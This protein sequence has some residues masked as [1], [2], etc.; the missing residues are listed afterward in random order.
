MLA[1][2]LNLYR[3]AAVSIQAIEGATSRGSEMRQENI[4]ESNLASQFCGLQLTIQLGSFG[5]SLSIVTCFAD[6]LG[7]LS[8]FCGI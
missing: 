4:D 5:P 1:L 2:T 7:C 3:T 6:I 8:L